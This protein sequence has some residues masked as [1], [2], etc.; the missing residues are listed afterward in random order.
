MK[1]D[2]QEFH[3]YIQEL[4][5]NIFSQYQPSTENIE[6]MADFIH[7]GGRCDKLFKEFIIFREGVKKK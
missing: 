3:V 6:L 7:V 4:K 1:R 2:L 5:L